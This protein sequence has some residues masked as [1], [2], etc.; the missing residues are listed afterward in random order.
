MKELERL[1]TNKDLEQGALT[2]AGDATFPA[3][4]SIA[5]NETAPGRWRDGFVGGEVV[6]VSLPDSTISA[7]PPG[8]LVQGALY[9]TGNDAQ[10]RPRTMLFITIF[11]CRAIVQNVPAFDAR[12]IIFPR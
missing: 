2:F 10:G 6:A 9:S 3:N 7:I 11:N 8:I 12:Y 4:D 5:I 1:S